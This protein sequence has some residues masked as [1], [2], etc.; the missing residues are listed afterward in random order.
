[1]STRVK[2]CGITRSDDLACAIDLGADAIGLVFH[3]KSPRHVNLH[4]AEKLLKKIPAYVTRIALFRNSDA[5]AV[6]QVVHSLD[7]D[8]L[9]F[10]GN[11]SNQFANQFG[12]RWYKAIGMGDPQLRGTAL[13]E[14]LAAYPDSCGLLFDSHSVRKMGGSGTQ[15][16]WTV[17]PSPL[18]QG[19]VLAGGLHAGNVKQ[20]IETTNSFAVDVSSGVESAPGIKSAKRMK[21]FFD[22]VKRV[23][24]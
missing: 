1:M 23:S 24:E 14:E 19:S 16:D 9:Q 11:E 4:Q 18:P 22:E 13:E 5:V 17:L 6:G 15:F 10:H 21:A 8:A 3:P 2:I 12:K 7:I 20:A